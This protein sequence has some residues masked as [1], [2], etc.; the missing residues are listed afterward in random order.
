MEDRL[1]A[2]RTSP[3]ALLPGQAR[4]G[5]VLKSGAVGSQPNLGDGPLEFARGL[6]RAA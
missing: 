2:P 3:L 4:S 6:E 5:S 1:G